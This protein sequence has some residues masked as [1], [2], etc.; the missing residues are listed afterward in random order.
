[1]TSWLFATEKKYCINQIR[2]IAAN[3]QETFATTRRLF[4][5]FAGIFPKFVTFRGQLKHL[6]ISL[7]TLG[8]SGGHCVV[9]IVIELSYFSS[10]SWQKYI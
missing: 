2:G 6:L 8:E 5:Q 9:D 7:F 1:M 3:V 10:P 4:W